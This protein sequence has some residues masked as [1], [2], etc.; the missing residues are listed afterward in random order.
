M[1]NKILIIE[2]RFYDHLADMGLT[3]VKDELEKLGFEY[4]VI[5]LYGALEIPAV[6]ANTRDHYKGY[7]TLGCVIRGETTHYDL[8]ANESF[9][10][11][12]EIVNA[13]GLALGNAIQ[14]VENESQAIARLDPK[15][16]NKGAA[17][18]RAMKS[19]LDIKDTYK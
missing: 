11:I 17:A 13:H 7:I 4:D 14:T 18:V 19:V 1:K 10:G 5:T 12:Y 3:G 9:R 8:V 16:M 6:L 15:Q 2:A